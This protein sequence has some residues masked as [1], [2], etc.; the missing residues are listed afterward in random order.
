MPTN[1]PGNLPC[2][3]FIQLQRSIVYSEGSVPRSNNDVVVN[4]LF[5][6]KTK[7]KQKLLEIK[8]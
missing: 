5:H 3:L 8:N 2:N 6:P 1:I 4:F 7:E